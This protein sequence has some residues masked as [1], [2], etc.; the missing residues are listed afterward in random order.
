M[1]DKLPQGQFLTLKNGQKIHYHEVGEGLPIVFLH[2]SGQG[3]SG[4][5]NFK[6]N[7]EYFAKNKYRAIMPDLL[8]FGYSSKKEDAIYDTDYH[9]AAIKEFIDTLSL[10]SVV[11]VGNSL[12]GALSLHF[13]LRYPEYVSKLVLMAP[14]GIEHKEAYMA[15]AGIKE[16][17]KL[18]HKKT[19]LDFEDMRKILSLQVYDPKI[20]SKDKVKER[21]AIAKTQPKSVWQTMSVPYLG[22]L[23]KDIKQPILCFWGANDQFL[24]ANGASIMAKRC[25]NLRSIVLS[26][27]G[28][29]VME[30]HRD[31]FNRYSM[32][33][34]NE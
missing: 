32:D 23:I 34:I 28:H 14:G 12:G 20:I 30:E 13:T 26:S 11:L 6:G 27:C 8:G 2:G 16:V 15:M 19:Q 7:A 24:S 9:L 33:F 25:Q 21:L 5:S 29:W 22:D 3:A 31:L 18:V 17:Y 10:N 4:Y 1:S